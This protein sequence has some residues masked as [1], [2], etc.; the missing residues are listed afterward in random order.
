MHRLFA[1]VVLIAASAVAQVSTATLLGTVKDGSGAAIPGATVT[2]KN[3]ATGQERTISTDASGNYTIPNL[4]V[5]HYQ[6]AA[7]ASGF[8]TTTIADLELQ[9]AQLAT[10]NLTLEVG[11]VTQNVTVVG[12]SPL[13]NTVSSAVSQ[14]VD[15]RAVETMPL[16]GRSFWQLTQLTPGAAY[17][18]GGQNIAQN[19]VSIRS[20]AVN[21]NVNGLPPVWTGWMLD[22]SNITETQLGGTTIQPN[23][24]ALQEFRVQAGNMSAEYGHT[25]TIV[26]A[27]IKSGGNDF[28]GS[29][30]WFLRNN[31][32]DARNF[33]YIPPPGS[34]KRNAAL[35]R[36]QEGGT[37]GGPIRRDKTF[38][39]IDYE[40]TRLNQ[41]QNFNN[42]VPSAAQLT[43]NFAGLKAIND[44]T[45]GKPFPNNAIPTQR[46]SQQ[47]QYF[48]PF[49]PAANFVSGT[50]NRAI[51]TNGLTQNISKADAKIDH[52][53]SDKDRVMGRYT[54][55]DNQENDPNPYPALG[56]FPL[57]S[58]GQNAVLSETHIFSPRWLNEARVSYYRSYF[59]FGGVMQGTDVNAAAGVQGFAG[60][61]YPGFPQLAISG[62]STFTGSPS[63]SR[64]K[65][66]RIRDWQYSDAATWAGGKHNVKFGW[67]LTHNTNTFISGSTSMGQFSF[68]SG[69]VYTGDGFADFLLGYPNS[70]QRAYFRN[71]WG[72][73]GSFNA[74]YAQ[75]DYRIASNL[76]INL[77]VRWELNPFYNGVRGQISSFDWQ[78]GKLILPASLDLT[79]QPQTSFLYPLFQDRF[80]STKDLGLPDSIRPADHRD[81]APRAGLAWKPTKSDRWV[82]RAG[83][84]IYYAF[85]DTNAINNSENVVPFNGTQTVN[86]TT[87]TPTLTFGNFF[88]G[89]PIVAPNSS[90]AVCSFGFAAKSC[91]TPNVVTVPVNLRSTYAQQWN[92]SI[93][94]QLAAGLTLDVAYV[95]N[96]AN[97]TQQ[98]ILRN[99]PAPGAGTIQTRRPYPQWGGINDGE[100]GG[101]Q[102]YHALQ[103]KLQS[104]EWHGASFLTSYAYAKCID[105]GTGEAGTITALYVSRNKALCDFDLTHNLS[106]SYSYALPIGKGQAFLGTMPGWADAVIGGWHISGI[107]TY[108]T[109]LPFT[110]S[111]STD[112][113]NTGV[114]S[115]RP[116]VV[117][118]PTIVG[119]A[120]CWFYISV[121]PICK[122]LAPNAT[123][124]FALPTTLTYGN[125]GRNILRGNRL[126]QFD[127]TVSKHFQVRES[128]SVELRGQF[129]NLFNTTTF[130]NPSSSINVASGATI[131]TTLNAAR[132]VELALKLHF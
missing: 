26:N 75:D 60:I 116:Q 10:A 104:R 88:Q 31:A 48:L 130:S 78:T 11:Q 40:N 72:N 55:A 35:H 76:T 24:D 37:L 99:D 34:T 62:Y 53:I 14:V 77:G 114:G 30:Y 111:V 129:F 101:N 2:V 82:I 91:S 18:P 132:T 8:K 29:A 94:R 32:M 84:G 49:M 61:P 118:A 102:H 86:N 128:K 112:V 126:L 59:N 120:N 57:V 105:N 28:H 74:F 46:I 124:A 98:T 67:E 87:P 13:M 95:G 12:D 38:F 19:G 52:Q 45:T 100:W 119:D 80:E 4:Q 5:A 15:T 65:Q 33:F 42:V 9:V 17:I 85:P 122:A 44:P 93:Q 73:T 90:G 51:L 68:G 103:V 6:I 3:I 69:S 54:I 27:T 121:N 106:V 39:F 97:R 63:D 113:A 21:V 25:P 70:V 117:G 79:A 1:M 81:W 64:P 92:L 107:S 22:G 96:R 108:H 7:T 109:G 20:S 47:A 89:Q 83:Y 127:F 41:G 56:S 50:T 71:L 110:P 36:N 131:G 16:N 115:Q 23:V 58:R 43:G 125:G 66:N 123:D